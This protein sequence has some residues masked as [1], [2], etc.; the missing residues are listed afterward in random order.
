M[1]Q[2]QYEKARDQI[3]R[4][5]SE[6]KGLHKDLLPTESE[7]TK[8]FNL[9]RNT[10][11]KSIAELVAEGVVERIPGKG[12]FI[13]E[14]KKSLSFLTW[15][16]SEAPTIDDAITGM[17]ANHEKTSRTHSIRYQSIPYFKYCDSVFRHI[18]ECEPLDI[19][20]VNQFWLPEFHKRGFLSPIEDVIAQD[21]IRRRYSNDIESCILDDRLYAINWTLCPLILYYN[22][23]VLDRAG[24]NPDNP[25]QTLDE[26]K[27]MSTM[28]NRTS[29]TNTSGMM[30]PLTPQAYNI[31]YIYPFLRAFGGGLQDPMKNLTIDS[32]GNLKALRWLTELY[33]QAASMGARTISES[34]IMFATN[35]LGFW[36]D[37]PNLRGLLPQL[38]HS[39]EAFHGDYGVSK[40]PTGPSGRSEST[41]LSHSLAVTK[42]CRDPETARQWIE[43]LT[44]NRQNTILYFE[45]SGM[46]PCIRDI[47]HDSYFLSDPFASVV[48]DQ[49]E[50]AS[51]LPIKHSLF[52][53]SLP[54]I[55]YV[56]SKI[57]LERRDPEEELN[58]LLDIVHMLSEIRG[59]K[60]AINL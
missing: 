32:E 58:K 45:R 7:L 24:L 44:T 5:V 60:Y 51:L 18:T 40:I 49:L 36:I 25:P 35:H 2:T 14:Q 39:G 52:I 31:S 6:L 20:Q 42:R 53:D 59:V 33:A 47:L 30:L 29:D 34:R 9:G 54:F 41:L 50:T 27:E 43:E 55:T 48:I 12:T 17:I 3:R 56:F 21:N 10:I 11:R 8:R 23:V 1:R 19:V 13:I 16:G 26:L 46:I 38:S 15:V 28:I 57:I 37:G 4:L 22:R